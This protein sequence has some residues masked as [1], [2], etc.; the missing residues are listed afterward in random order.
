M[1]RRA[2]NAE[3]AIFTPNYLD[4]LSRN[5]FAA[6]EAVTFFVQR[7]PDPKLIEAFQNL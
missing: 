6:N 7:V 4:I 1:F 3:R 5:N 2:T